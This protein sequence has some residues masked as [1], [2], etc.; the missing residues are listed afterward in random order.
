MHWYTKARE[1]GTVLTKY[2]TSTSPSIKAVSKWGQ[3]GRQMKRGSHDHNSEE[4]T[5]FNMNSLWLQIIHRN[6]R[7]A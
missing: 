1:K 2:P 7:S 6:F 5:V 3:S 4:K